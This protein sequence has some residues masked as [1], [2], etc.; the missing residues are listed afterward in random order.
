[1]EVEVPLAV[2]QDPADAVLLAEQD[3]LVPPLE[4]LQIQF[5]DEPADGKVGR[6]PE[7][8]L[9]AVY[10]PQEVSPEAKV[11]LAVPQEP[12]IVAMQLEPFQP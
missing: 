11:R 9:Q 3:A 2:P 8:A 5:T 10:E 12:L 1:V 6:E 7:P 4:P